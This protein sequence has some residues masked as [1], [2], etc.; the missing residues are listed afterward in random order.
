MIQ[1]DTD[2]VA[3]VLGLY[4]PDDPENLEQAANAAYIVSDKLAM[5]DL[6]LAIENLTCDVN[7]VPRPV[8]QFWLLNGRPKNLQEVIE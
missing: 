4:R 5:T 7:H 3:E 8:C 2:A 1:N 6:K